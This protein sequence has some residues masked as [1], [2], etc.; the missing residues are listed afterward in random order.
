MG[1]PS[2][3][4][5]VPIFLTNMF[6]DPFILNISNSTLRK[7]IGKFI[8]NKRASKSKA[9]Y[10]KIGGKSP[11][12]E[13]TFKLTQKL[14][15]MKPDTFFTYLMRYTPPYADMVLKEIKEKG[16]NKI[17]LFSMYPQYSTTTSLSSFNDVLDSL[18][19]IDFKP[20]INIIDR[21]FDDKNFID[22]IAN[23]IQKMAS[24]I[25]YKDYILIYSAHSIPANL[26]KRGDPYEKEC[27]KN[28][29]LVDLELEK[30]NIN[31]KNSVLAYQSKLGPLKWLEP[32]TKDTI[33]KY[34]NDR[35]I[36]YPISFTIDN[37]ET[38]YE[39]SIEYKELAKELNI[40]DFKVCRCLNDSDDFANLIL[41]LTENKTKEVE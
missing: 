14:S 23:S 32:S 15:K 36:I 38:D 24:T 40:L 11:I 16:I 33:K 39:L 8:V 30:R 3:L 19:L 17:T 1:G 41:K 29:N 2:S 21:Y 31:F 27:I 4:M 37:S 7:M 34:K 5:E 13:L 20:K 25:N 9:I 6:N 22:C 10:E 26:I 28:K 35:I 12:V 18:K